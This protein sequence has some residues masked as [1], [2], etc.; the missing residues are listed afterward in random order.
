MP[1]DRKVRILVGTRKGTYVVEG[2]PKRVKWRVGPVAHA[3]SEIYHVVA[4]PRHPGELYAAVNNGFWGPMVQRSRNWGKTWKEIA[5]PLTPGGK[6]RK[7]AFNEENPS[8]PVQR[9]LANLWHIEPGPNDAPDTL[10]LGADPHLL[11]RTSDRGA[12]WEPVESINEHP[13]RKDWSPGAGGPCLHTIL[14]DPR[15]SQRIY[16]GMSAVGTFRTDDGGRTWT[17]KNKG[18]MAPF[19]PN[20]Y[21]ETG[22]CVH[23]VA[24]D[25][26]DPDTFYRQDHGGMYVSHNRMDSWT[27]IGKPLGDDFGFGVASP[28]SD[29]GRAY[30]VRLDGMARVTGE[31]HFQVHEW[32]DSRRAWRTLVSP[33][34]FPGHFGVQREG[35]ATDN[36]DPAGIYVGTTTGQL[37]MS[38]D[39]GRNWRQLPFQLPGIH[40]VSVASP[41]A[42]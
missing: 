37:F 18:V 26:R 38:P 24:I 28:P 7:P 29:P 39:A 4:D 42:G 3:G 5:T 32:N 31:G 36:L 2:D 12:S 17:P 13:S 11:F 33:K 6:D 27:R 21:P 25:S 22:Q 35:I 14:L 16:V 9:P 30:F 23:H 8:V 34:A 41:E 40:S 15:D 10:Y 20:K 19:L 1:G